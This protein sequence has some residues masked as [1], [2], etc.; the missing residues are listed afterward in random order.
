MQGSTK[1]NEDFRRVREFFVVLNMRSSIASSVFPRFSFLSHHLDREGTWAAEAEERKRVGAN[2]RSKPKGQARLTRRLLFVNMFYQSACI[3]FI[4]GANV[5]PWS[6]FCFIPF[7]GWGLFGRLARL[8]SGLLARLKKMR[9]SRSMTVRWAFS[10]PR[11]E[12]RLSF[13]GLRLKDWFLFRKA[14][15]CD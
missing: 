5:K 4:V 13:A 6:S 14:R 10:G 1:L 3:V 9:F 15:G 2:L 8:N 12:T 7:F 11:V